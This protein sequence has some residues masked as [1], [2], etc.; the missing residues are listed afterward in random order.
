MS[1]MPQPD[2]RPRAP[3]WMRWTLI[4]SLAV[5]LAVVGVV[6]GT[7]LKR[8][9]GEHRGPSV[10]ALNLGAYTAALSTE[11]RRALRQA[12]RD[13]LPSLREVRASQ[14]EGQ[15]AILSALRADPF[16]AAAVRDQLAA[17]QTRMA[18]G[19]ALGQRLL[20]DRLE[21]MSAADRAAFA[22]RLEERL[23]RPRRPG[24]EGR[25]GD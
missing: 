2:P 25:N 10:R 6:A 18:E 11:D 21:A 19:L 9:S 7:S 20:M 22:D 13:E 15:A 8:M 1:D 3:R 17:Q 23:S 5:N 4:A 24:R 14:A 12:F 16:D